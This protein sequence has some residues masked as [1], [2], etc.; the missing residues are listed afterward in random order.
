[1]ESNRNR[2]SSVA[3]VDGYIH[4]THQHPDAVAAH[5]QRIRWMPELHELFLNAVDKLGG[6]ESEQN[7]LLTDEQNLSVF[8][9]LSLTTFAMNRRCH[10]KE[11]FEAYEC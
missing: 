8:L 5:K 7:H 3:N 11:Y 2:H 10:T 1:M 4:S 6:P 9:F